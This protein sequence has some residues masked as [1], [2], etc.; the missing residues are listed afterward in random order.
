MPRVATVAHQHVKAGAIDG[1]QHLAD[2]VHLVR[3]GADELDEGLEQLRNAPGWVGQ[4][5]GQHRGH[6]MKTVR[7]C[8]HH[9]E[10]PAAAANR[11]KQVRVRV[12]AGLDAASVDGDDLR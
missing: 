1:G 8:R 11:P 10:I 9:A 3:R 4:R 2:D 7:E 6:R 12:V 5:A